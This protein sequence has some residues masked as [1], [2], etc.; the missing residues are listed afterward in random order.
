MEVFY[1]LLGL[2]HIFLLAHF[3]HVLLEEGTAAG[4]PGLLRGEAVGRGVL[5]VSGPSAFPALLTFFHWK[6]ESI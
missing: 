6:N 5:D 1:V 4:D 2:T 3:F